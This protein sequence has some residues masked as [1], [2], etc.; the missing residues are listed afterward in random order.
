MSRWYRAPEVILIQ[1][2]SN[3]VDIWSI[4]CMFAESLNCVKA[5]ACKQKDVNRLRWHLFTGGSCFPVSP[6][7]AQR[8]SEDIPEVEEDDQLVK[9]VEVLGRVDSSF[10]KTK[11]HDTL[12]YMEKI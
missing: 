1:D 10:L 2:Y 11:D 4:G 8:L 9:I 6:S 5:Q 3:K 12:I 7:K